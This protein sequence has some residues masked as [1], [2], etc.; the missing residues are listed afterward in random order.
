MPI[1]FSLSNDQ[2]A[3]FTFDASFRASHPG[4]LLI[5]FRGWW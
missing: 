3:S 4:A 2:D 5:F 1:D